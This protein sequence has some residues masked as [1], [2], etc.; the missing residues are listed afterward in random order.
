MTLLFTIGLPL[1]LRFSLDCETTIKDRERERVIATMK[2]G[3]ESHCYNEVRY[4]FDV[5]LDYRFKWEKRECMEWDPA[6]LSGHL[7]ITPRVL[8]LYFQVSLFVFTLPYKTIP[9][10]MTRNN[11]VRTDLSFYHPEV[12]IFTVV[13]EMHKYAR[14]IS[15]SK[16]WCSIT[17]SQCLCRS[18]FHQYNRLLFVELIYR[19]KF[20]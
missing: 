14:S 8:F 20:E 11:T 4:S 9:K 5:Q 18:S 19:K 12:T 1:F 2:Y 10:M 17:C 7:P 6:F 16:Q 3:T 15:H 13:R